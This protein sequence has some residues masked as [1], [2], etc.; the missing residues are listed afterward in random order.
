MVTCSGS[1][2]SHSFS[3]FGNFLLILCL[4]IVANGLVA[5]CG[6]VGGRMVAGYCLEMP[7]YPNICTDV[8]REISLLLVGLRLLVLVSIYLLPNLLLKV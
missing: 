2:L 1:V 4:W 7:E 6:M 8:S 3:I 5:C